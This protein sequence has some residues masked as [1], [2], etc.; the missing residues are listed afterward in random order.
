[1]AS[2]IHGEI[3][4]KDGRTL[5]F[6][7]YGDP[8]GKPVFYFHGWP[9]AAVEVAH[10]DQEARSM[11]VRLVAVDRPGM[12]RSTFQ[13]NRRLLDWPSDVLQL[14]NRLGWKRFRILGCSGGG[15]Y[16]TACAFELK[17]FLD[18][19]GLICP[20]GPPDDPEVQKTLTPLHRY[21]LRLGSTAAI[22]R[23]VLSPARLVMWG[24]MR[25]P[26]V[27]WGAAAVRASKGEADRRVLEDPEVL[28]AKVHAGQEAF[29]SGSRGVAWDGKVLS[30]PWGFAPEEIQV[31]V[32]LW[33]GE[34][35]G[36]VPPVMSRVLH[37][38]IPESQA[39]FYPDDGHSSIY[40][41]HFQE[42]L[43]GLLAK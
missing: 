11:G 34:K 3:A 6:V 36:K 39:V 42:I 2:G 32:R 17:D 15:P 38:A 5:S 9:G 35:D 13:K 8:Q 33:H 4:L 10:G 24:G 23:L 16:A 31:S 20:M 41:D 19:V 21:L 18:S 43:S 7:E 12:G 1:M 37:A 25:S 22:G 30:Q 27:Q 40:V 28:G 14:A 29:R 26:L